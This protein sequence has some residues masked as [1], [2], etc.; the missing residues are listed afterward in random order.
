VSPTER[1]HAAVERVLG[2]CDVQHG[3]RVVLRDAVYRIGILADG[4]V[5]GELRAPGGQRLTPF[6]QW[7][8]DVWPLSARL[9]DG[10][11]I[12]FLL[13]EAQQAPGGWGEIAGRLERRRRR[14][15]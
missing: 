14:R 4:T 15:G 13:R 10:R 6:V 2:L 7:E 11:T 9:E 12:V 5:H 1:R 3:E 8:G